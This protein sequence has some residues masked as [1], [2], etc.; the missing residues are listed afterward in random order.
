VAV[1]LVTGGQ[2][3]AILLPSYAYPKDEYRQAMTHL[4]E[5][6]SK[7]DVVVPAGDAN[8]YLAEGL[9]HYSRQLGADVLVADADL[10]DG[11]AELPGRLREPR[12]TVW[13][14]VPNGD[15]PHGLRAENFLAT[16]NR[17]T[18]LSQHPNR[19]LRMTRFQGVTLVRTADTSLSASDQ[20]I[21]L[22]RWAAEF[23]V[24]MRA[25]LAPVIDALLPPSG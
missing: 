1:V 3:L 10:L 12:V 25:H 16:A 18:D 4:V 20:A 9:P 21:L 19:E 23:D 11:Y 24:P 17:F 5:H 2:A 13:V 7:R 22:L 14:A 8:I 15:D 6:G